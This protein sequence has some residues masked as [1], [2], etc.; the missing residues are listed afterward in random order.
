MEKTL[1]L[2]IWRRNYETIENEPIG[3]QQSSYSSL[4]SWPRDRAL[5]G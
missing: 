1:T 3:D 5:T 2:E 4:S